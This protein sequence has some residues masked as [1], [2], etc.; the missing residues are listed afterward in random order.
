MAAGTP[1]VATRT[2][3]AQEVVEDQKTGLIVQI[4]DVDRIAEA[5]VALL[6][7]TDQRRA[8]GAHAHEAAKTQFSLNRMVD[9]IEK[10]YLE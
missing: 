7:N 8:M 4:G 1:V 5:V 6:A 2:E 9:E 10:I 3:G